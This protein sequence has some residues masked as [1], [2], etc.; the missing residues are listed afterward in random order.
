[1]HVEMFIKPLFSM[2][3]NVP[4]PVSKA[5][6]DNLREMLKVILPGYANHNKYR[7]TF[8]SIIKRH[9]RNPS[10]SESDGYTAAR[11]TSVTFHESTHQTVFIY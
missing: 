10:T 1:M 2:Y 9:I 4:F 11:S 8:V 7:I 3:I 5:Y 6:I